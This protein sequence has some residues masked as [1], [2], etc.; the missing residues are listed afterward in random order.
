MQPNFWLD[1]KTLADP[2]PHLE[3]TKSIN[4]PEVLIKS[5]IS[6]ERRKLE[7]SIYTF[8]ET[9]MEQFIENTIL[10]GSPSLNTCKS[11]SNHA[12][13]FFVQDEDAL[14]HDDVEGM[15]QCM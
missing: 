5:K 12:R 1:S 9:P 15:I 11:L 10:N 13:C 6:F 2:D 8:D 14:P 7:L 3:A 4:Q